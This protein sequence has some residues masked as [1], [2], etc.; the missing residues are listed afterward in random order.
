M[1]SG[2]WMAETRKVSAM[3]KFRRT[4]PVVAEA[5]W[6]HREAMRKP[7]TGNQ[8]KPPEQGMGKESGG[9]VCRKGQVSNEL[10]V[11]VAFILLLFIPLMFVMYLKLGDATT[12]LSTLQV[13]FSVAR[14]AYLVNAIG[15]MGEGSSIITEVYVPENV[16][17]VSFRA[18]EV[19]FTSVSGGRESDVSRP[20]SFPISRGEGITG[21]GRYRL[22]ITNMGGSVSVEVEQRLSA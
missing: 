16:K 14:I 8:T 11:V 21:P 10:L 15:Y 13:H 5:T 1:K 20:T 18:N 9:L 7:G 2:N 4:S 6:S 22:E 17:R 3:V 19:V 12:D